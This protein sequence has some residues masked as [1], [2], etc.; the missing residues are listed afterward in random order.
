MWTAIAGSIAVVGVLLALGEG[1]RA[2]KTAAGTLLVACVLVCIWAVAQ[3]HTAARDVNRAVARIAAARRNSIGLSRRTGSQI[4]DEPRAGA[5]VGAGGPRS[6]LSP[7]GCHRAASSADASA[8]IVA[9]ARTRAS[10]VLASSHSRAAW[11]TGSPTTVYSSRRSEP[12]LPTTAGP[13]D[14]DAG[15]AFG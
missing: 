15:V 7:P 3:G 14:T 4:R 9:E 6:R 5:A 1:D 11:F 12:T 10:L 13:A 8:R 2:W